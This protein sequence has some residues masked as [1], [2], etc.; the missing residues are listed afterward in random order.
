MQAAEIME[1]LSLRNRA[2]NLLYAVGA[3]PRLVS[4]LDFEETCRL[5]TLAK[6]VYAGVGSTF[7]HR[8]IL[9]RVPAHQL[10][11]VA[12]GRMSA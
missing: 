12:T 1:E 2:Y 7:F 5:I 3:D 8:L 6:E 10:R 4:T 9:D 11:Y